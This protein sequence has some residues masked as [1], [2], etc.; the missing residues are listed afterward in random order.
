MPD[1]ASPN[2]HNS[3]NRSLQGL[4]GLAAGM[5]LL[6]H[7]QAMGAKGDFWATLQTGH[8]I[9]DVGPIA[10]RIF[11]FISGYLIVSSLW[12][13]GD[14][15]KF[16]L[17]RVLRIYPV[18]LLLHLV[19][20][21]L[22]P[23]TNYGWVGGA[24]GDTMGRLLGDPLAWTAHFFSNLFFLPGI[25][26]LPIAQQNAWSLS[27]EAL[28]YFTAA[29]MFVAWKQRRE[30]RSSVL[31]WI[32]I[33]GIVA[34]ILW[35]SDGWFFVGGVLVWWLQKEGRMKLPIVG[36]FDLVVLTAG[37]LLFH[38]RQYVLAAMVLTL[39]FIIVVREQ[40]WLRI[41]LRSRVMQFLGV[42]SY[43]LYLVHPFS[44]EA[45][46]R[47]LHQREF[48]QDAPWLF[49]VTGPAFAIFCSWLCYELI[50]K[51][52]TRWLSTKLELRRQDLAAK[53][54]PDLMAMR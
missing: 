1:L 39:F 20:F 49:W 9:H 13:N 36:P 47:L 16:A 27:Y 32:G 54:A 18:F 24:T 44:L 42:I 26:A 51:R 30:G 4:R 37:F 29:F 12:R 28:F 14:V 52:F 43:S 46:R 19:M 17:N 38:A 6:F 21:T 7:V 22:G 35:D 41:L 5:V 50:E 31:W 45:L 15:R 48:V 11:F 10:V 34:F 25:L 2:S 3:H 23:L 40:G 8:W 33:V 53:S